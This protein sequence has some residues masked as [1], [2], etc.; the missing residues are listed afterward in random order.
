VGGRDFAG[1]NPATDIHNLFVTRELVCTGF[2]RAGVEEVDIW[3]EL[4]FHA[5][6]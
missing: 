1:V 6:I 3:L 4:V 2:I 5:L